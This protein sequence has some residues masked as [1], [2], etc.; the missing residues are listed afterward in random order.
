MCLCLCL[1][2]HLFHWLSTSASIAYVIAVLVVLVATCWFI[3][4]CPTPLLCPLQAKLQPL[5][6]KTVY[7]KLGMDPVTLES[8]LAN[9]PVGL[10]QP[11]WEQA[12]QANPD[13]NK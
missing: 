2:P 13:P 4:C 5:G 1:V 7:S 3:P 12:K 11:V 6:I 9:P 10:T 8:Y